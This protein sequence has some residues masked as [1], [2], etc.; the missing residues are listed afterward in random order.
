[1]QKKNA[2]ARGHFAREKLNHASRRRKKARKAVM[3]FQ[4]F[5]NFISRRQKTERERERER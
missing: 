5:L 3:K 1:M 2:E 4:R